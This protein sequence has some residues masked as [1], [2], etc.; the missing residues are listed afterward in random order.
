MGGISHVLLE[1]PF[2]MSFNL[3]YSTQDVIRTNILSVIYFRYITHSICIS[4]NSE[5]CNKLPDDSRL[6]PK[7]VGAS[8]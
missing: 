8:I 4:S 1:L 7:H 5:G 2:A 6:L 3:F